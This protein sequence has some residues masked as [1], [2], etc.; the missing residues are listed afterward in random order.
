MFSI[1][2]IYNKQLTI[3]LLLLDFNQIATFKMPFWTSF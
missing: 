2:L 3:K 1:D